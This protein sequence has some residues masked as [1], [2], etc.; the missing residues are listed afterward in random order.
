MMMDENKRE[1][2]QKRKRA[3]RRK[4][5][6]F[7]GCGILISALFLGILFCTGQLGTRTALGV[8]SVEQ[9]NLIETEGIEQEIEINYNYLDSLFLFIA[10]MEEG[11]EGALGLELVDEEDK[12]V[13]SKEYSLKEIEIG[14]FQK[15]TVH[16]FLKPGKYTLKVNYSG[17]IPEFGIPKVMVLGEGKNLEETGKCYLNGQIQKES[18]ALGYVFYQFPHWL[19]I[20]IA[21]V[22]PLLAFLASDSD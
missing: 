19:W 3:E 21:A 4:K 22:I 1:E 10:N 5:L 20:A 18:L 13:F 7:T 15:I 6:I 9:Y 16:K 8:T 17:D 11:Q 12:I 14:A 2:R